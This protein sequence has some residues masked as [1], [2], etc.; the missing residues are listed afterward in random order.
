MD[1]LTPEK[2]FRF[3][4]TK[5]RAAK[6]FAALV[7][8][9]AATGSHAAI[10]NVTQVKIT[11]AAGGFTPLQIS[12]I[13][14][15]DKNTGR[16]VALEALGAAATSSGTF[17]SGSQYGAHLT[18][19]GDA[20]PGRDSLQN[21]YHSA[22]DAAH[23]LTITLPQPASIA[24]V[25]LVGR[26]D[27]CLDRDQYNVELLN[28]SGT[29]LEF[30]PSISVG[31]ST[32]RAAVHFEPLAGP[33]E[34]GEWGNVKD[35]PLVPVSMANLP[36]GRILTYSGSERRSWPTTEQTY[37]TIWD[38][39]TDSFTERLHT[40]HNMFCG[41]LS[42]LD[43]GKVF[44]NGGRNS[45]NSPWVTTFDYQTTQWTP[46]DNMA[47]GGR[48]YATTLT[49]GDGNVLTS[50]GSSTNTKNPDLWS[51]QT[52][53]RVLNGIDFLGL[54]TR[55][56]RETWFPLL[57]LAPNGDVFHFWDP[58]ESHFLSTSGNGSSVSA[59]ANSDSSEHFGGIQVMYDEGKL[60]ISGSNDGSWY[61]TERVTSKAF[62]VDLNATTPSIQ[63]IEPMIFPRKFHQ[64][65]TLP[66]GEVL[67]V[68][69][70]T[71]AAKFDDWGSVLEPEIWNPVTGKWRLMA[72]MAVPRDYHSTALL[73]TDGR[74][75]AG[76]GGYHP[77]NPNDSGTHADTEI[78]S[79]AYLFNSSGQLATRPVITA[80]ISE[81][82]HGDS[83]LVTGS[84]NITEFS[85][86][87]MSATTHAMN[88]DQ[89][90]YRP[91]F[92]ALGNGSYQVT[93]HSNPNVATPGY[94][95]LF[96]IDAA[97]VPSEA[98]VVRL[99]SNAAPNQNNAQPAVITPV[100]VT[101]IQTGT[102]NSYTVNASGTGLSY[103]WNF[104]DGT[105]DSNFSTSPAITHTFPAPGRYVVVATVRNASGVDATETFIQ[106][107]YAP[108]TNNLAM[109]SSG[110]LALSANNEIWV[111]NPD[112][113]SVA[114]VDTTTQSR[115][116]L[117]SV[118]DNPRALALAPDGNIWVTNKDS[119]DISIISPASRSVIQ[120]LSLDASSRPHGL[121]FN[122]HSA[123]VALEAN[124][125]LVQ[126]NA[127]SKSETARRGA[128]L[129]PR[130][131]SINS[132]GDSV[133]VSNYI[134]AKLVGEHTPSPD[135]S[136]GVA[137]IFRFTTA[138]NLLAYQGT[139][140][141]GH[142]NRDVS[143]NQGPGIP[144]Y[145]GPLV[146]S[147]DG[148]SAWVPSKQD[149]ILAG[150]MRGGPGITFD[151]TVRAVTSKVNLQTHIEPLQSRVDH[152]NASVVSHAAFD[153]YGLVLFATLEGN[154]QIA[155]I[156]PQT[157]IEY[158]RF[159]TGRAP[160]SVL[161]SDDG[162]RLYVHNFLD[163]TLGIY[164]VE[165][166]TMQGG[167]D[168]NE[169]ATIDLV[170]TDALSAT[171]LRGKQL[172]YDSHDDR[173]AGLDYMSCAACHNDGEHDGRTWDFTSLGE[174]LRNTTSLRG[175][176]DMTGRL[177][178]SANF[179]EV[180]DFEIQLRNFNGGEGLMADADFLTG[181]TSNPFGSPKAGL[182][183]DLDALA[184][185]VESLTVAIPSP[186]RAA[187]GQLS[188]AATNGRSLFATNGCGICHQGQTFTDSETGAMHD[189]GTID[190][191]SGSRNGGL[192]EAIDTPSLLGAWSSAP[193]LHDGSADT[194]QAAITGHSGVNLAPA[195]LDDLAAFVLQI[196]STESEVT[197]TPPLTPNPSIPEG[198][199][200]TLANIVVD[201]QI[202]DWPVEALVATDPEDATGG[203]NRLDY[204]RV[205]A[206]HDADS[207]F[208]R[209]DNHAPNNTELTWGYSIG[210][211]IDGSVNGYTAGYL[212]I[213]I[214]F[215]IEGEQ[216][217]H[218][219]GDGSSW[220]W[221]WLASA[222][223]S[224]SG[225]TT[226]LGLPRILVGNTQQFDF[227]FTADN[228]A[229]GGSA[230]DF[231]PN[232]VSDPDAAFDTRFLTYNYGATVPPPPPTP[233][234][235]TTSVF[236][237]PLASVTVDGNL[238][239]WNSLESFGM[240]PDDVTPTNNAIDYLQAW[241]GHDTDNFYFAWKNDGPTSVTWGNAIFVDTD[242]SSNTGFRGFLNESSIG[243][244]YLLEG[245][246]VFRYSG[247]G[248]DW[249]WQ[250]LGSSTVSSSTDSIE[251]K[252]PA[253]MLGNVD[254][255][256]IFFRGDSGAL[257]GT[258]IDFFPDAANSSL[259]EL[260]TRRFRYT[261]DP[262]Q[263]SADKI[264]DKSVQLGAAR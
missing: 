74:V 2:K 42:M 37:S 119:S 151:Q 146:I 261:R 174:G 104:G 30:R 232:T 132:S 221:Q 56:D 126:L 122:S 134:V 263:R 252:V 141:L 49:L 77:S 218:Y 6:L 50:M 70:N 212:P 127:A 53:S 68:G 226:E 167:S 55:H 191:D 75:I 178:W 85:M 255:I 201:G 22:T 182:S 143:E 192:L 14:V 224:L 260:A 33:E 67:T 211:D 239:E 209:Y 80:S 137:A 223:A 247:A 202:D 148:I 45:S 264:A 185:Y 150:T 123:Y 121:V 38:P 140:N 90:F 169:V 97:G 66:T 161:V 48:W 242:L 163:R 120:T 71:T 176:G 248:N 83:V 46:M 135:V 54:R 73:M 175:M 210:I 10:D 172:F 215:L 3:S 41:T 231:V 229:V 250:Y 183:A 63:S 25:D 59:N 142:S 78:Y 87:R 249:D 21:Y 106:M 204:M 17:G 44:V 36:D 131:L 237:N 94:W 18:I 115:S 112:N 34:I 105:G 193:Y 60:L 88:T 240:D 258:S 262:G 245:G 76:G 207:L 16:D 19:D 5:Q 164:D 100:V 227:I 219:I 51:P 52:G 149:N 181:T 153:P 230:L 156:N 111:V 203:N 199:F 125:E 39:V 64:F 109:T 29:R 217:Y 195:E 99:S 61:E 259:A 220:A 35:W 154:R 170:T 102:T 214:D 98:E 173:L 205:W 91:D 113:D 179:D 81:L 86:V 198:Q 95:M 206:A 160:Q 93:M 23:S 136:N 177:H 253:S 152:D 28:A 200:S 128:G 20:M 238:G 139:I 27:C 241:A 58:V 107:V 187:N 118:G 254:T 147:P 110:V 89:R 72:P 116:G 243:I 108:T 216:I 9:C 168:V 1:D 196:D 186:H 31:N 11:S 158:A 184:A 24:R 190:S 103:S 145:L 159:S 233:A 244:D 235:N 114:I 65:I 82:N 138:A 166:A 197:P 13:I 194:L 4:L 157:D 251:L 225:S 15:F 246:S 155:L 8:L 133:Y 47:S 236:H 84:T 171:V 180:Q 129:R 7:L 79:P 234:P 130:H 62:T 188:T 228:S 32:R 124:G 117:I 256:D 257:G 208:L 57:S 144:N 69:G 189:I 222:Q 43:D 213:G 12:E 92:T 96:A 26:A 40:G 165:E 162:T 101:P